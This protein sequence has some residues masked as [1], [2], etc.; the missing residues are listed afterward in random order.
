MLTTLEKEII[1]GVNTFGQNE[2]PFYMVREKSGKMHGV[3]LET[4]NA[5]V[6]QVNNGPSIH[7]NFEMSTVEM[8]MSL[9]IFVGPSP[10]DVLSQFYTYV[11][12]Y[13]FNLLISDSFTI[14]F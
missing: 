7:F 12:L 3:L 6:A 1:D 9:K 13:N 11:R 14:N 10:T 8:M 5:F 2:L 4:T